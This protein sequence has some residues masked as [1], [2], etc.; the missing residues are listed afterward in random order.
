MRVFKGFDRVCL[1][2]VLLMTIVVT[3]RPAFAQNSSPTGFK[4]VDVQYIAALGDP[5]A[6]AGGGAENWGLWPLDPGP[7]GCMLDNYKQVKAA[8]GVT[9]AQ[10]RIDN[11]DWWLEEHGLI[12]EKPQFPI[13][14]G[15]Y[16]VTG[17]REVTSILTVYPKDKNGAQRWALANGATLYDVT[18]LPCRAARYRPVVNNDAC[19]PGKVQQ[20]DF[21]VAPGA[22]MPPIDGC[23]KQD[24]AVLLV[25]GVA[26]DNK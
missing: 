16:V 7:R 25:V 3:G 4:H 12:M 19:T 13:P 26:V 9:P 2:M 11:K 8:G 24:Y 22:K 20:Q 10:W 17:G 14:P 6:S 23:K 1:L 21:P 15:Q 5:L 18:H